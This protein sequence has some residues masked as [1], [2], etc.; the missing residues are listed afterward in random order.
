MIL[1]GLNPAEVLAKACRSQELSDEVWAQVSDDRGLSGE[2]S[3]VRLE[4]VSFNGKLG[5]ELH[6]REG[7]DA[8]DIAPRLTD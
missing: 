4:R 5:D 6:D 8:D 1:F 7:P 2:W 3:T